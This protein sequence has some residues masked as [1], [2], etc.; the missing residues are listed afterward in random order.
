MKKIFLLA[1]FLFVAALFSPAIGHA[2]VPA[3]PTGLSASCQADGSV[4]SRWNVS[5]GATGY[6][7]RLDDH[8]NR[9]ND[10]CANPNPGDACWD[11]GNSTTAAGGPGSLTA[12]HTYGW[13]I[14]ACNASG[15][16][17]AAGGPEF[18]CKS[19]STL[20]QIDTGM[21]GIKANLDGQAWGGSFSVHYTAPGGASGDATVS[22]GPPTSQPAGTYSVSYASGA[23]SGVGLDSLAVSGCSNAGATAQNCVLASGGSVTY[24]FNFK[25]NAGTGQTGTVVVKAKYNDADVPATVTIVYT[26]P[27]S[28]PTGQTTLSLPVNY[29]GMPVGAYTIKY[30]S[31]RPDNAAAGFVFPKITS[32]GCDNGSTDGENC[33]LGEGKTVMF[34]VDFTSN[35]TGTPPQYVVPAMGSINVAATVNDNWLWRGGP[36]TVRWTYGATETK[37]FT[38]PYSTSG[39]QP[40]G[41]YTIEYVSGGPPG[42]TFE[43]IDSMPCLPVT[44]PA[45]CGFSL[46][47]YKVS[48]SWIPGGNCSNSTKCTLELRTPGRNSD[49]LFFTLRFRDPSFVPPP[50]PQY[51][52]PQEGSVNFAASLDYN[53][54]WSGPI[55]FRYT[56]PSGSDVREITVP[57]STSG[58]QPLGDYE[59]EYLSGGPPGATFA[60]VD[61]VPCFFGATCSF[62][63]GL[64]FLSWEPNTN[65]LL[66]GQACT[67]TTKCAQEMRTQGRNPST[68]F[69]TFRFCNTACP[70]PSSGTRRT[71]THTFDFNPNAS[72]GGSRANQQQNQNNQ[73][74][75]NQQQDQQQTQQQQNNQQS[76]TSSSGTVDQQIKVL[77][78]Q[79]QDLLALLAQ[80]IKLVS[81]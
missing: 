22:A 47:L 62:T 44:A 57:Y 27:G 58:G 69:F 33:V 20:P 46:G 64:T 6:V 23:P 31:G 3:A 15:C 34:T 71:T 77:Q 79:I 72:G 17:D 13:W 40:L 50:S 35:D 8:Q 78:Q 43:G 16:G 52:A 80:L 21:I 18:T 55:K 24:T 26:Y 42:A 65:T 7:G 29:T 76:N 38:V 19:V 4:S 63:W 54:I 5:A 73:Q 37:N 53:T 56:R 11:N 36:V 9:W 12:G 70:K 61:T 60:G 51:T 66:P 45:L 39:G 49:T 14:H 32:S 1:S 10:D 59:V 48:T 81:K 74:Q 30:I 25:T 67:T 2:Q 68:L 28:T 75:T 41:F